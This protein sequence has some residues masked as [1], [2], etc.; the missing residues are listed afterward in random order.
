[1][2]NGT[3]RWPHCRSGVGIGAHAVDVHFLVQLAEIIFGRNSS[4]ILFL[5]VLLGLAIRSFIPTA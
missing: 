2:V 4:F 3:S 1:S 5:R